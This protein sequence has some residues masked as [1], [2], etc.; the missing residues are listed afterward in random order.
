MIEIFLNPD[1]EILWSSQEDSPLVSLKPEDL[2]A[3][4]ML[5]AELNAKY[6]APINRVYE[7]YTLVHTGKKELVER[8]MKLMVELNKEEKEFAPA[9]VVL[10]VC[11][12]F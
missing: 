9:L 4:K 11:K 6:P 12:Y 10:A 7:A 5:L 8:A 3:V 1:N 2:E